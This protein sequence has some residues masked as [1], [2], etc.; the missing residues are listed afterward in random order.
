MTASSTTIGNPVSI[1][2]GT[3][4]AASITLFKGQQPVNGYSIQ[5]P[6]LVNDIWVG[7]GI[8][9]VVNGPGCVRV[10]P[11]GGGYES[12]AHHAYKVQGQIS[13]IGGG[14]GTAYTARCW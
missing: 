9:A 8:P 13:I 6:D 7:E 5:N 10:T 12:P 11:N 14:A 3:V 1:D 4:D 2:Y